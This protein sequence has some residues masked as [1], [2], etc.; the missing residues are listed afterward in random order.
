MNQSSARLLIRLICYLLILLATVTTVL[1]V[2]L[3]QLDIN[4]YRL[5]L[6]RQLS[7]AL[8][9]P[10]QIGHSSL[11]FGHGLA[12]ALEDLQIGPD[13][14]ILVDIPHIT[15]T[16]KI[17]P[18]FSGQFILDQVQVDS[19]KFQL[20]LPFSERPDK[21]TSQQIINSLGIRILSIHNA[22]LKIHQ[23]QDD[24]VVQR[25]ELANLHA[26]L[27]GWKPGETGQLVIS[28]KLREH[29]AAFLF[30]TRLPS[31]R[32]PEV[33]RNEEHKTQLKIT[34]FSTKKIPK[35]QGQD[36]PKSLDLNLSILGVPAT[37]TIFNAMLSSSDNTEQLFSLSGRWTS[38]N[39]QESITQLKG[40]LLKVPLSG[41][42]YLVRQAEKHFLA[43]RFGAENVV[44]NQKLLQTWR[45]P[46]TDKFV[47][48]ELDRLVVTVNKSW[49]PASEILG[50]PHIGAEATV[51]NL[52]WRLPEAQQ[53]QDLSV[54]LS[55][56]DNTL[57][58][59]NGI[60]IAANQLADFSGTIKSPFF[61][62]QI[63]LGFNSDFCLDDFIS[64]INLPE[65]WRISGNIPGSL[66]LT[67]DLFNPNFQLQTNLNSTEL[68]LGFLFQKKSTDKAKFYLQGQ[69]ID[70]KQL[71]LDRL[72]FDL[73]DFNLL[74]S[75]HF[76]S[77]NNQQKHYLKAAPFE[78]NKLQQFSPLLQR[79]QLTGRVESE[80]TQQ[81]TGLLGTVKLHNGGA[82]IISLLGDVTNTS[83]EIIL[84]QHG[85]TFKKLKAS[86]G[87]SPFIVDGVFTNWRN[88]L[89]VLDLNGKKARARD[90]VFLNQQLTLY[91]LS[92]QLR[93]D[94]D[95]ISFSPIKVRLEDDT[96]ALVNGKVG[97]SDALVDL[98]ISAEQVDVLDIIN[99]F[100][101]PDKITTEEEIEGGPPILIKVSAKQGTLSGLNFQNVDALIT[102]DSN[103]LI[104]FPLNFNNGKG[105]CQT[106]VEY[107]YESETAPLKISGHVENIDASILHQDLFEKRGLVSG[108]LRGDFYIEGN[109]GNEHFWQEAQ[110]G[111]HGQIS[112]GTLRKF[113]GLAKVFSLLNVSQIFS[114]KLPDMDQ[115]GMPFTLLEGN[116][117]LGS[118]QATVKDLEV[119]SVA[120]NLSIVGAHNLIDD[121]MDFTLG[122]MP[123]RTVDKIITSIPIAGWLLAGEDKALITAFFKID[124]SS[125]SPR[126]T[127]IPMSTISDTTVGIFKRAFGLPSRLAKNV[128]VL[129]KKTPGKKTE[130]LKE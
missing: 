96:V 89:L 123:L 77:G 36:Y 2:F 113:H 120:M 116:I 39:H 53:L 63:N 66:R 88:P 61:Q 1:I 74:A 115:E 15:A 49:N 70:G 114:G 18:L 104:L 27:R 76:N 51:S 65:D 57:Q 41:G 125:E 81:S 97:F 23:K 127:A 33:W 19:P 106:R 108:R 112:N 30:E 110:G 21:G 95:S 12:L 46:N 25:L 92:G 7:A 91:D 48:G 98:D 10:V 124:G 130:E 37:G 52:N 42:I 101:G 78:L 6:E 79:I 102:G 29:G 121:S 72:A 122:V 4:D 75:G 35:L 44:L 8:E 64:Q 43:G 20:W 68:Q 16:L 34:N 69:L 9:Q 93:I 50:L 128:G 73:N 13:H 22:S 126:V 107:N 60:L 94:A 71:R 24:D 59:N 28:G 80:I 67:G 117:Q 3:S 56:K 47:R 90:L 85:F 55:L 100:V 119:T 5:S 105:L 86:L 118:G 54:E 31:S 14:A 103:R 45:I 111:I 83:G 84:D 32:D 87:E 129:F 26:N 109:P 58:I 17:A 82:H 11:T 38:S 62:P 40:E 99:L